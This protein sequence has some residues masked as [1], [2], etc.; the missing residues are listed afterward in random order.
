MPM[1]AG[2]VPCNFM[3]RAVREHVGAAIRKWKELEGANWT[4]EDVQNNADPPKAGDEHNREGVNS[5]KIL[6]NVPQ[7]RVQPELP[8]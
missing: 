4:E 6:C 7:R 5:D 2:F 8:N 3:R 1:E